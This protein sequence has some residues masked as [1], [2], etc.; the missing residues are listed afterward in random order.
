MR[1]LRFYRYVSAL[2]G[3]VSIVLFLPCIFKEFSTKNNK[4]KEG[5]ADEDTTETLNIAEAES[6]TKK[7]DSRPK[8]N[9][10][11]LTIHSQ[12]CIHIKA[13]TQQRTLVNLDRLWSC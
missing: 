6:I 9:I 11:G 10:K 1:M 2:T 12:R 8:V 4:A 5:N 13:N 3:M 7:S